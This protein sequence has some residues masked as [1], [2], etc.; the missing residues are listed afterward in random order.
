MKKVLLAGITGYLGRY[1][2][3]ELQARG[4]SIRAIA[5]NTA[6]LHEKGI[7]PNE[8]IQAELTSPDTIRNC[9][10]QID[11]VIATVGGHKGS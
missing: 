7:L 4:F 3:K 2:A 9:C 5:R 10:R 8:L 11:V 6:P 1:I